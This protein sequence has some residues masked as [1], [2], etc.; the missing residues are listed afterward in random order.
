MREQKRLTKQKYFIIIMLLGVLFFLG[1]SKKIMADDTVT[2]TFCPGKAQGQNVTIQVKRGTVVKLPQ[3]Y[4]KRKGYVFNCWYCKQGVVVKGYFYTATEGVVK[5]ISYNIQSGV[6]IFADSDITLTAVWDRKPYK[7][8]LKGNG[9][10]LRYSELTKVYNNKLDVTSYASPKREGY[11]FLGWSTK[12]KAKKPQFKSV[13]KKNKSVTLYAVWKVEY[14]VKLV[15]GA[16]N[17][18]LIVK[19]TPRKGCNYSAIWISKSKSYK[20][21]TYYVKI[22]NT[23]KLMTKKLKRPKGE[24]QGKWYVAVDDLD[25]ENLWTVQYSNF[26]EKIEY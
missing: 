14:S 21:H 16:N 4:W 17:D 8:K 25:K 26:R 9:G 20:K 5:D 6:I 2:I 24:L 19:W 11:K 18:T 23:K 10:T 13:Y 1:N 15:R 22:K 7:V 3:S 12:R